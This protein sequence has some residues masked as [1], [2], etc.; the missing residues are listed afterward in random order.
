MNIENQL[1]TAPTLG[2][3]Y[4]PSSQ[5][6][7]IYVVVRNGVRVSDREYTSQ[8]D[9]IAMMEKAFWTKVAAK[10]HGEPVTIVEYDPKKH[11]VW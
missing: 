1:Q 7:K 9:P 2:E 4:N 3:T 6:G 10:S 5:Y 8:T 11:R